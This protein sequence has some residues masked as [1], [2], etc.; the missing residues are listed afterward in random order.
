[1]NNL[2]VLYEDNHIIVVVKPVNIL[3]QSDI[4]NDPDMLTIIKEY[5]KEKYHKPGNVYLGL[6]HRLDRVVGGVMVF[7][8]TSKGASRLS[9][10]IR[11]NKLEKIYLAICHGKVD[12]SDTFIDYLEKKDDFSTIVT[13]KSHGK[14]SELSYELIDY[15][16]KNDLSLVKV[17]LKTG[18]HH[19]IRVQFASRN[20]PLI[21]DNRYGFDSNKEIGLFAYKLSFPH[22]ITKEIISFTYLPKDKPFNLFE[23][24]NVN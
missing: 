13:D 10:A 2:N 20:H 9:D 22:P 4:T 23:L 15:D 6:V 19:Q 16:E 5:L 8:K 17:K 1:M 18:R 21:G 11:N 24:K 3:S 7:A 12:K 14:L